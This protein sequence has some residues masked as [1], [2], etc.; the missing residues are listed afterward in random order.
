[1]LLAF[2]VFHREVVLEHSK[3]PSFEN[4][5]GVLVREEPLE[6]CMV[7]DHCEVSP[8]EVVLE[9]FDSPDDG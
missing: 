5:F 9:P 3:G 4:R 1:M 2:P 6:G 7:C 8:V